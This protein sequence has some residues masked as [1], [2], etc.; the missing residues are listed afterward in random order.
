MTTSTIFFLDNIKGKCTLHPIDWV[1]RWNHARGDCFNPYWVYKLCHLFFYLQIL[2]EHPCT[3]LLPDHHVGKHSAHQTSLEANPD[4]LEVREESL[5]SSFLRLGQMSPDSPL[6]KSVKIPLRQDQT[7]RDLITVTL[8]LKRCL[9]RLKVRLHL[10]KCHIHRDE[11]LPR[12]GMKA[13]ITLLKRGI[14]HKDTP[15]GARIKLPTSRGFVVD[16]TRT[17]KDTWGNGEHGLRISK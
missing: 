3:L 15:N 10:L 14:A 13:F 2:V 17:T 6:R 12:W 1:N 8:P 9:R 5:Q 4:L 16:I 7:D 11:P